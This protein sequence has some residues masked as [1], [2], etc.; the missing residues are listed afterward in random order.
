MNRLCT[1][2]YR[3]TFEKDSATIFD[4]NTN[5]VVAIAACNEFGLYILNGIRFDGKPQPVMACAHAAESLCVWHHRLGHSH[6]A[7]IKKAVD[8]DLIKG[9][10]LSNRK[11][12]ETCI[13]CIRAKMTEQ[14]Y[15][16]ESSSKLAKKRLEVVH[17]DIFFL[18][19]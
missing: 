11:V 5:T 3:V 7:R 13:A 6:C 17:C 15:A 4:V 19:G 2:G 12:P 18:T 9:V 14:L 8:L 16:Q 10:R 1:D